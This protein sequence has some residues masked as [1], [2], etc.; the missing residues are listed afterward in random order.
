[1]GQIT[2][3]GVTLSSKTPADNLAALKSGDYKVRCLLYGRSGTGKSTM[4]GT[5]PGKKGVIDCDSGGLVYKGDVDIAS[6]PE[7]SVIDSAKPQAWARACGW[8]EEFVK[9]DVETIVIDSFTTLADAC[10][11]GVL[12]SVGRVGQPPTFVEWS[13]QMDL[14]KEF[15]FK[16]FGSG[17][18]VI[19]VFHEAMD[20]DELSGQTWCLPL[21]TGKLAAKI[22]GYHDEVYHMEPKQSGNKIE[23]KIRTKATRLYVAKSRLA[24][25]VTIDELEDAD[26]SKLIN[27][28]KVKV[29]K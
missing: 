14:M 2:V 3:N 25:L 28:I 1:M 19:S 11:K 9:S 26:F 10:M 5:F 29:V 27:K 13:R 15:L 23:Y 21:I 18:N 4:A 16:A 12:S 7:D 8:L 24:S 6:I 22:P 17:K 20:K